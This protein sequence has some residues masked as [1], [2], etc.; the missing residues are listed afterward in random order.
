M[1]WKTSINI[2]EGWAAEAADDGGYPQN[3]RR[4]QPSGGDAGSYIIYKLSGKGVDITVD[5]F[6]ADSA[7]TIWGFFFKRFE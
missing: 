5:Y 1:K 6:V 7:K 4:P 2:P 3:E